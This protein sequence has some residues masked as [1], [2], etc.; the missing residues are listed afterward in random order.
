MMSYTTLRESGDTRN[1]S[2]GP[3]AGIRTTI[4]TG[5]TMRNGPFGG[6]GV[7]TPTYRG[8]RGSHTKTSFTK[9]LTS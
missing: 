6:Q 1:T 2:T 7:P 8:P 3:L 9:R 4:P 5:P